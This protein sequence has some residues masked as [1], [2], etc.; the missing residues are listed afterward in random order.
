MLTW[1]LMIIVLAAL[2]VL[3]TFF[4]ATVFGRGE[5]TM[6]LPSNDEVLEY[7]RTRLEHGEIDEIMFD[8]VLRG[9]RQDQVDDVIEELRHQIDSLQ[10]RLLEKGDDLR[11]NQ[12]PAPI[13][14]EN[15]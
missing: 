8:T 4:F 3:F 15:G 11:F 13:G 10:A 14:R 12:P 7:N 2:V 5:R 9:Y 6:P 1:I